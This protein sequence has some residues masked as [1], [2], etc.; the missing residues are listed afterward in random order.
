MSTIFEWLA[1]GD[2]TSDGQAYEVAAL[3]NEN[4][5]LLPD[6]VDTLTNLSEAIR[7]HGADALEKVHVNIPRQLPDTSRR[8]CIPRKMALS[9]WC[10]GTWQ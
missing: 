3:V 8:S 4:I 1:I 7:G 6:L 10:V 9:P 5:R 2:L